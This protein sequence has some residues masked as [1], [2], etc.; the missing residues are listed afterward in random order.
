[1]STEGVPQVKKN[2]SEIMKRRRAA[3]FAIGGEYALKSLMYFKG[4][5][6][7]NKYWNNQSNDAMNR[8]QTQ[9]FQSSTVVG[10][11]MF[12]GVYYGFYLETANDGRHQALRPVIQRY[13]GRFIRD[14]QA[15]Y[16]D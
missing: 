16:A 8:M 1:M 14:V 11:R 10:F 2:I 6:A 9:P 7:G 15:L 3:I 5:Q 4:E 12:H 13:A